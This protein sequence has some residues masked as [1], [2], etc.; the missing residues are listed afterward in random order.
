MNIKL[1]HI[2]EAVINSINNKVLNDPKIK[3]YFNF[4]YSTQKYELIKILPYIILR[5]KYALPWQFF[6]NPYWN[7]I[8][9][10][11]VIAINNNI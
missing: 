3:I 2:D 9:A 4:T 5:I 11:L 8:Y 1:T 7:T 6:D 10:V